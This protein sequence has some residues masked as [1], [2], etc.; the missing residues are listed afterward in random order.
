VT[1][2]VDQVDQEVVLLGL[3][4]DVL[5]V[6]C[7]LERGVQGDGSG[8]DGDT[9]LL[10]VGTGIGETRG[11]GVGSR[12]NTGTLDERVGKGR[13]AVIDCGGVGQLSVL[14]GLKVFWRSLPW[15]MTDMLR[16]FAGLS[17]RARIWLFG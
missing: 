8:L 15:A 11:T 10:L 3:D 4:G 7:I 5:E 12:D 17:M 16:M 14:A 2:R 13:L 1:G 6:L 9:T